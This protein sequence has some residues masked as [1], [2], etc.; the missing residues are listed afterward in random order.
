MVRRQISALKIAGSNPA[1]VVLF[2]V[3][4][5]SCFHPFDL[6]WTPP[7]YSL[8]SISLYLLYFLHEACGDVVRPHFCM[9]VCP[10]RSPFLDAWAPNNYCNKEDEYQ[11]QETGDLLVHIPRVQHPL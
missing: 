6:G 4:S 9:Y 8:S 1:L 5:D 2:D 7:L 3:F 11:M 10:F